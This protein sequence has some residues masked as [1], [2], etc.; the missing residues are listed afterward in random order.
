MLERLRQAFKPDVN[1][2]R[3]VLGALGGPASVNLLL[4][5]HSHFDH[6]FDTA[7]WAQL[8]G[9]R[10]IGPAKRAGPPLPPCLPRARQN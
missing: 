8:T 9:A 1:A 6:S 3:R 10:I 5:G 2:V 4:T 7:T